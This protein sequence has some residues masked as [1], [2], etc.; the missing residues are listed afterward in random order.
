MEKLVNNPLFADIK[1]EVAESHADEDEEAHKHDGPVFAHRLFLVNASPYFRTMFESRMSE[2]ASGAITI[3]Q[4]PARVLLSALRW[5]YCVDSNLGLS[6]QTAMDMLELSTRFMLSDLSL[7][8]Q[9]YLAKRVDD[10]TVCHFFHAADMLEYGSSQ[11]AQT[12]T[13]C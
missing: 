4:T 11:R 7:V 6:G 9:D 10:T 1:L 5:M 12:S 3:K 13:A 8:V 2:R